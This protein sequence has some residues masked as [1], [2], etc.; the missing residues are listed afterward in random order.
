M[1]CFQPLADFVLIERVD[2]RRAY[3]LNLFFE[4]ASG[5]VARGRGDCGHHV[6]GF[7]ASVLPAVTVHE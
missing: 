1:L 4:S 2:P 6:G 5:T 3:S 7:H